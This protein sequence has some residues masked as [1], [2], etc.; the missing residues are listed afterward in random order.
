MKIVIQNTN[1]I[2]AISRKEMDMIIDILPANLKS[3]ADTVVLCG[4]NLSEPEVTFY[5]KERLVELNCAVERK[6]EEHTQRAIET[7]LIGLS[8]VESRKEIPKKI[9]EKQRE[10]Y[11]VK[12]AV[13]A[14][15]CLQA[16]SSHVT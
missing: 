12:I 6:T 5:K 7:F 13:M 10:E 15:R 3:C 8:I 9:S 16:I 14:D 4:R 11:R 1:G 2:F